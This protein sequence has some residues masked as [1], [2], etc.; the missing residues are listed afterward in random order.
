LAHLS[1]SGFSLVMGVLEIGG[2]RA[3]WQMWSLEAEVMVVHLWR[4]YPPLGHS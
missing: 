2:R 1:S 3:P 4:K